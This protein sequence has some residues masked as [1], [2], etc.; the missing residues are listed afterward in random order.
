V[1]NINWTIEAIDDFEQNIEFLENRFSENEV[2]KFINKSQEV[3]DIIS[4]NPNAFKTT[5]YKKVHSVTVVA[6]I[7]LFYRITNN[8]NIELLRFWNNYQNPKDLN[9]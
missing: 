5:K 8:N 2:Q 6:Q 4:K 3:I 9:L 1:I 7:N